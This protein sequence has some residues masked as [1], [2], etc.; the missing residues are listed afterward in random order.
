MR[1]WK[2]IYKKRIKIIEKK[3]A[4]RAFFKIQFTGI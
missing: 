2:I 3:L 1:K 4:K